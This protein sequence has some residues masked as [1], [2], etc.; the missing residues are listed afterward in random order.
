M[1]YVILNIYSRNGLILFKVF[2]SGEISPNLVTLVVR[3]MTTTRKNFSVRAKPKIIR[4]EKRRNYVRI[5]AGDLFEFQSQTIFHEKIR[6]RIFGDLGSLGHNFSVQNMMHE[7]LI[8]LFEFEANHVVHLVRPV[9][10]YIE[11]MSYQNRTTS[12]QL[13]LS[14]H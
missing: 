3:L 2:S 5:L 10:C 1:A 9:F 14:T 13:Y 4:L 7:N 6:R 12:P 8:K 11:S